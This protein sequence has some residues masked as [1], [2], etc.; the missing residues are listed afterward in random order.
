[1]FSV[2]VWIALFVCIGWLIGRGEAYW[3]YWTIQGYEKE[4]RIE[5]EKE[6]K[7]FLEEKKAI[8]ET[9]RKNLDELDKVLRRNEG[10]YIQN[11]KLLEREQEKIDIARDAWKQE[12]FRLLDQIPKVM[13]TF[14]EGYIQGRKWLADAFAEFVETRDLEVECALVL[15]SNPAWKA[16]EAVAELRA[17]R[18]EMAKKLKFLEYQLAS[19]EEYFPVLVEYRDAILDEAADLRAGAVDALEDI[20]PALA[21]GYLSREEYDKLPTAQ[22]FQM[23]LDRYWERDKSNVEIG[24]VYERYIGHLYE[25]EGWTVKYQGALKGF[26]DF[27]RDL[28][29]RKGG[30]THIVQCKCWSKQKVIREKHIMQLFGTSILYRITEG[31]QFVTPIFA[32]T[33]D[34]SEEAGMVARELKVTVR[35]EE[36]KRYPMI[37]CNINPGT[38]EKIYHLPF[39]QQYDRIIIGDQVGEFYAET[40]AKAER[41]GFR[42]AYR[43]QGLREAGEA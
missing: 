21:K 28:I 33:T 43:W 6:Y 24:R 18:V 42:R 30:K 19:Y 29:C 38:G 13:A 20:D 31:I 41:A 1:M 15:K 40:V 3:R 8:A 2:L 32:T 5:Y 25:K 17:K 27:G 9:H 10:E 34:L 23:A 7:A 36:L 14:D 37:K 39:D 22:K 11:K 26:E 4:I 12:H 16:A 35:S